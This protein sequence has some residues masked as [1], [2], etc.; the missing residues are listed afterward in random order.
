MI[1]WWQLP[2]SIAFFTTGRSQRTIFAK[3]DPVSGKLS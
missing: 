1:Q 2:S 3:S